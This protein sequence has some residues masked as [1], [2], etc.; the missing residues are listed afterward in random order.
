M[1]PGYCP[2]L[3]YQKNILKVGVISVGR[4]KRPSR[5]MANPIAT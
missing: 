3:P 2:Y 5:F 1:G 4:E